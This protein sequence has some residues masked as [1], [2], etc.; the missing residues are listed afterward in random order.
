MALGGLPDFPN[1]AFRNRGCGGMP[2][3]VE[4]VDDRRDLRIVQVEPPCGHDP[5]ERFS[6]PHHLSLHAQEEEADEI[7]RGS[8]KERGTGKGRAEARNAAAVRLMAGGTLG[9]EN[10]APSERSQLE[11]FI[12]R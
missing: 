10:L 1:L 5:A 9:H 12:R 4:V 6:I 7:L 11:G 2:A 8:Q 3:D